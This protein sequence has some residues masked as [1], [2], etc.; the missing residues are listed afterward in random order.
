[1]EGDLGLLS[2]AI[3]TGALIGGA[4]LFRWCQSG[5]C[6]QL[7]KLSRKRANLSALPNRGKR[8]DIYWFYWI[9]ASAERFDMSP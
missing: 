1:M 9:P 7:V 5:I 6:H 4:M 8:A 3:T 2:P